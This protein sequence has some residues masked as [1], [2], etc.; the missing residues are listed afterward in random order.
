MGIHVKISFLTALRVNLFSLYPIISL[1]VNPRYQKNLQRVLVSA[2][3]EVEE[4]QFGSHFRHL[5]DAA[6][7]SYH[8]ISLAE[9]FSA[10]FALSIFTHAKFS[11][12]QYERIRTAT[13]KN[14]HNICHN[15]KKI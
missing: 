11:K 14:G 12:F 1:I 10:D 15:Y 5:I 8:P 4:T 7:F 3:K 13:K 6:A 9:V 2:V